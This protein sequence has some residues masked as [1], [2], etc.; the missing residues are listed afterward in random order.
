VKE[1]GIYRP[2]ATEPGEI[3]EDP[4]SVGQEAGVHHAPET[5]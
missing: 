4:L 1:L 2:L 5:H 3:D